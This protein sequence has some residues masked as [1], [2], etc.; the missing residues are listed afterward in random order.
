MYT[1]EYC[2]K[3][4][5]DCHKLGGHKVHCKQNP[6]YENSVTYT[7]INCIKEVKI[8]NVEEKF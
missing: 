5:D 6:K 7:S 2:G 8:Q 1:C 4:F 3:E